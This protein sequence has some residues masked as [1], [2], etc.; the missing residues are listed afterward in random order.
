MNYCNC[1][2]T[3][4]PLNSLYLF[5]PFISCLLSPITDLEFIIH[6]EQSGI[7]YPRLETPILLTVPQRKPHLSFCCLPPPGMP[8]LCSK[9]P[10]LISPSSSQISKQTHHR[11]TFRDSLVV[12]WLG[13]NSFIAGAAS[14]IP[15]QGTK[16]LQAAY[17]SQER[18]NQ[19]SSS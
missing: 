7:G 14:L 17:H 12:Q 10:L 9:A 5:L 4:Y 6:T 3:S 13:L 19:L 18:K 8:M 15:G 1:W 16:V 2:S 11:M